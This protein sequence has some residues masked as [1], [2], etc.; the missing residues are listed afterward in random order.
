M[1]E[2]PSGKASKLCDCVE[3]K[4]VQNKNKPLKIMV[5]FTFDTR[6]IMAADHYSVFFFSKEGFTS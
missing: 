6:N 2:G 1:I 3:K 4:K 5:G